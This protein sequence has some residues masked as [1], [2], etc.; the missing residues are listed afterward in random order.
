MHYFIFNFKK[1]SSKPYKPNII[2][3]VKK[4]D[5]FNFLPTLDYCVLKHILLIF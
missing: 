5:T 3:N 1:I 4:N 2:S